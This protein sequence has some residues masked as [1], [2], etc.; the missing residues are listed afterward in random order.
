MKK[1]IYLV[2]DDQHETILCV[3]RYKEDAEWFVSLLPGRKIEERTLYD[4]QPPR[5]GYCK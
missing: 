3:F 5:N 4:S 1:Y 2:W